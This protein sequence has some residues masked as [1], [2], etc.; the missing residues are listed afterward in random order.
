[1]TRYEQLTDD[2]QQKEDVNLI[3]RKG[4][5]QLM[6]LEMF[7]FHPCLIVPESL[8]NPLAFVLMEPFGGDW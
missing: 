3:V 8:H 5:L 4:L 7:I 1:M 6:G 2:T